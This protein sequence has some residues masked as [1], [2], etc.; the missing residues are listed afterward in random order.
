MLRLKGHIMERICTKARTFQEAEEQNV[1]QYVR[2]SS[3]QRQEIAK[4]LRERVYRKDAPDVR[5]TKVV[6]KR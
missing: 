6:R 4:E 3:V 1:A 5:K 2:M